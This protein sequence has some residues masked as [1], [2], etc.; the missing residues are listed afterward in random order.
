MEDYEVIGRTLMKR[1]LALNNDI[2]RICNRI[3]AKATKGKR[4]QPFV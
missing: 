1:Y 3:N 4:L 2:T